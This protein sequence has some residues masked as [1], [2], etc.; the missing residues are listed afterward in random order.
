MDT[1][2][3][4]KNIQSYDQGRGWKKGGGDKIPP[5]NAFQLL[6]TDSERK[7]WLEIE[8]VVAEQTNKVKK[9]SFFERAEYEKIAALYDRW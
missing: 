4:G 3:Q 5:A 1:E 6:T 9:M 8:K 7:L 2:N